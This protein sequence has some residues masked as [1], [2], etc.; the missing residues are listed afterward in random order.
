[1]VLALRDEPAE[2]NRQ[3]VAIAAELD[4]LAKAAKAGPKLPPGVRKEDAEVYKLLWTTNP[5]APAL[6]EMVAR[7]VNYNRLNDP[8]NFPRQLE[9]SLAVPPLPKG[10]GR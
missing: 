2:S 3:F 9:K 10:A 1:M 7:A 5:P 4:R 8:N 6:R